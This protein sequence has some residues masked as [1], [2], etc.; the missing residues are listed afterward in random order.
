M[1]GEHFLYSIGTV[2][3]D[4]CEENK[5]AVSDYFINMF[6]IDTFDTFANC[7]SYLIVLLIKKPELGCKVGA[8]DQRCV[9]DTVNKQRKFTQS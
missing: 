7:V 6:I 2:I 8:S 3:S 4:I 9:V 5:Y 1:L